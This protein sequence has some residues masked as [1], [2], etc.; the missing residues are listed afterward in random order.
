MKTTFQVDKFLIASPCGSCLRSGPHG[1]WAIHKKIACRWKTSAVGNSCP[2]RRQVLHAVKATLAT[3]CSH[4]LRVPEEI[5]PLCRSLPIR[6]SCLRWVNVAQLYAL[7]KNRSRLLGNG[8][9][10]MQNQGK[11]DRIELFNFSTPPMRAF[12]MTWL[13]FFLCFFAWF[14]IA[15]LMPVVRAEFGLTKDQV[16]WCII[17]S[18]ALTT[19][20]RLL[21]GW[22]CD[23]FGP[24]LTYTALLILGSLPV[25]GIGLSHDF[26][27]FLLFRVAIGVIGASFVITQ[28]HTTQMFAD[29]CVGTA[30]ATTA[31]WGNFGGGVTHLVM[32]LVFAFFVST[33]GFTPGESWRASMVVAGATCLA[34][35]VAYYFL[36][37]DTPRGNFRAL[38]AAGD[39]ARP[40]A[41]GT[42]ARACRDPRV[43][44]L[45]GAYGLCFGIELTIDNVAAMYFIDHFPELDSMGSVRA[46]T[47]AGLC[48][49]V[50]GGMS[51]FAR[52][53]G[54]YAADRCGNKWGFSARA[55]WL[56]LVLFCEGL[57][58]MLFS[59]MR[60][61]YTAIPA[62]M[63][64]GLFV[65]MA[66][67]ATYAVVP[68]VN[69][70]ALGSVAGIVG[71]GGNAGAVFSGLL[72]K[73]D[74]LSWPA[75]FF[76]LGAVVTLGSFSSLLITEREPEE[77]PN[78]ADSAAALA[79][80]REAR[81]A[82]ATVSG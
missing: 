6:A 29:R 38:R 65:H 76:L 80:R 50:F 43:W 45:F 79:R 15:P 19:V 12:H 9:D 49:S 73:S 60:G 24:R 20:A 11:A 17:G 21:V 31:G 37:Q 36:T 1:S 78:Y 3:I 71:A 68:F 59:Q 14:G 25:M 74:A 5:I 22:L 46:L 52:T 53:L 4:S 48:A 64:C 63:L 7:L 28:Y 41:R 30:N 13:A 34:V 39:P 2:L 44:V 26:A 42:F 55:K 18:V 82:D 66:A 33:L 23:R 10:D 35:G 58:L 67:G 8:E 62:L 51:V 75:A 72:F 47:I 69:R 61:L 81:L 27:T 70:T 54:G 77:S 32:P 56:V 40:S 16:G 57:L